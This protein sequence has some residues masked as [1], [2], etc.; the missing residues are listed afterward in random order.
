MCINDLFII[1]LDIVTVNNIS[2]AIAFLAMLC[3]I[4]YLFKD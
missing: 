3:F 1:V 4:A 2:I